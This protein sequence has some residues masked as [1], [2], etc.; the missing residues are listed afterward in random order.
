STPLSNVW[1]KVK[2]NSGINP[3]QNITGLKIR[4][5]TI[6]SKKEIAEAFAQTYENHSSNSNFHPTFLHHKEAIEQ[7]AVD[8]FGEFDDPLNLPI[9]R[10]ELDNVLDELKD[11]SAGPDDIPPI[12]PETPT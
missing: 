11:T 12:F 1:K 9:T 7:E 6:A 8:T 2:K 4:G 10:Q 3:H 5:E